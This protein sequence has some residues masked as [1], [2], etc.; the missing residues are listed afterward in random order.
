MSRKTPDDAEQKILGLFAQ[1]PHERLTPP[2]ILRRAGFG[3]DGLRSIV[4]ALRELCRDG[5]LVRLKKNHYA[6]PD[7][8]NL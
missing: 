5:R 7:R 8:Q 4:D 3:R 1:K 2:E 6:L